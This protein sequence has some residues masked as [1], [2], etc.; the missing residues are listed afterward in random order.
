MSGIMSVKRFC[1]YFF[2]MVVVLGL[3]QRTSAQTLVQEEVKPSTRRVAFASKQS[4]LEQHAR[5]NSYQPQRSRSSQIRVR[6]A[7]SSRTLASARAN[8]VR[9]NA[10]TSLIAAGTPLHRIMHTSQ[11]SL[12]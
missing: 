1:A 5:P 11:L 9:T 8:D 10:V 4:A 7:K 12:V 3:N 2:V 6:E